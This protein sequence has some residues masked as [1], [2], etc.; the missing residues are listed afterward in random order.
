[1]ITNAHVVA[2]STRVEVDTPEGGVQLHQPAA[3]VQRRKLD[4]Q[5]EAHL[6][7]LTCS[8]APEGRERWTLRLLADKLVALE[9]VATISYETVRQVLKKTNSSR[10]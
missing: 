7:A 2:G 1:M 6:I 10:G 4:G 5:Q 3:V 9:V 8:K